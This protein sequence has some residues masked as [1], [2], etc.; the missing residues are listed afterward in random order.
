[1]TWLGSPR[2]AEVV[3]AKGSMQ[4][5]VDEAIYT[6]EDV[7]ED[8][9][10]LFLWTGGKEANVIGDLLLY[11][12]GEPGNQEI[13]WATIDTG[14]HF[15]EMRE[16][17]REYVAA[18]GDQSASTT[19][20]PGGV[21]VRVERYDELLDRVI[22]NEDDPRGYHGRWDDSVDLPD[23]QS[24]MDLPRTPE[25]WDVPASCGALKVV[26]LRRLI[27]GEGWSTIVTGRRGE[28]PLTGDDGEFD[29]WK[30]R[31][32]PARHTRVNPLADWSEANVYAYIKQESVSLPTLYTE[33]GYRHTDSVCCTDE[34]Q[35]GEY[36]EGGRDPQKLRDRQQLEDLGY[37]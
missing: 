24:G 2:R 31:R 28:D 30:D 23:P 7:I 9:D 8:E 17:R 18:T 16:F 34:E 14:N 1:M 15:D 21:A 11:A 33:Q 32:E 25:E 3:P 20:P 10:A 37:V 36:G 35:V 6:L 13:P 5:R 27:N 26:P 22:Q 4:Q 19:G 29:V 12:V